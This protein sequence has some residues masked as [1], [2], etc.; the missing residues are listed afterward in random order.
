MGLSKINYLAAATARLFLRKTYN[1]LFYVQFKNT[2]YRFDV[3]IY[4]K[5]GQKPL[6]NSLPNYLPIKVGMNMKKIKN[7]TS[8]TI[9]SFLVNLI[10][11]QTSSSSCQL[12]FLC[13]SSNKENKM[14]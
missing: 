4:D 12:L 9:F 5:K 10:L 14:N 6:Q 2:N 13:H 11:F 1:L 3:F 8:T 7:C